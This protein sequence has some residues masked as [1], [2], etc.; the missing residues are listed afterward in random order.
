MSRKLVAT[1][2]EEL[3]WDIPAN[4]LYD[5]VVTAA[6]A[7]FFEEDI[8]F[9]DALLWSSVGQTIGIGM[10]MMSTSR[11]DLIEKFRLLLRNNPHDTL[12]FETFLK[13]SLLESYGLMLYAHRGTGPFP[14][15]T[16]VDRAIIVSNLELIEITNL[17]TED[18][19]VA[20]LKGKL[21]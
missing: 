2:R 4:E 17:C 14:P 21:N 3:E 19:A 11:L 5:K 13:E 6:S 1:S 7:P 9:S 10:F 15:T 8:M 18:S 16:L 20:I 12:E